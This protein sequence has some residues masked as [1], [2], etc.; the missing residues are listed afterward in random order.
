[1][2]FLLL[3][4]ILLGLNLTAQA[5]EA[6][7]EMD[8][9]H[10]FADVGNR[11][12]PDGFAKAPIWYIN[13][14]GIAEAVVQYFAGTKTLIL[15]YP[16][17]STPLNASIQNYHQVYTCSSYGVPCLIQEDELGFSKGVTVNQDGSILYKNTYGVV[18]TMVNLEKIN[19]VI[20][21]FKVH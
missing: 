21:K 11:E 17:T 12:I 20:A 6:S 15:T 9:N 8:T 1:M 14:G 16:S 10:N 19:D 18:T 3:A 5:R 7:I 4:T 13:H 2:K